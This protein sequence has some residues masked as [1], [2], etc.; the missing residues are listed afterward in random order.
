MMIIVILLIMKTFFFLRIFP[1]LTP[2]VVMITNVVY[3]LRIFLLFY[4]ILIFLFC[5]I[6]AVIGLGND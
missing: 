5:Q 4:T 6:F 1:T 3:D 2:I